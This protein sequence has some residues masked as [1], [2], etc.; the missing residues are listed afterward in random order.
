MKKFNWLVA[1]VLCL[2][3]S[4]L[5]GCAFARQVGDFLTGHTP[6][7]VDDPNTPEDESHPSEDVPPG[8]AP[9]DLVFKVLGT[10][11]PFLAGGGGLSATIRWVWVEARKRN[12]EGMFKSVVVGI[13]DAVDEAKNGKLDK[14]ALYESIQGARDLFA[15]RDLFDKMVDEIKTLRD[16][17]NGV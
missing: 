12:L 13:K 15:N 11:F 2:G 9:L 1:L 6:A 4:V 14:A 7:V 5:G 17:E 8:T 16:K 10:I 3:L